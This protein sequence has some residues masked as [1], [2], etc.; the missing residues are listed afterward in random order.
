[1]YY[2][3]P[4]IPIGV[5]LYCGSTY[6]RI[7]PSIVALTLDLISEQLEGGRPGT[8]FPA[9]QDFFYRDHYSTR[10]SRQLKR[11][12][13]QIVP[14]RSWPAPA[15]HV[16]GI[17]RQLASESVAKSAWIFLLHTG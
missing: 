7:S 6:Y 1:V 17:L 9:L 13:D 12:L 4:D 16:I 15:V 2:C 14:D 5:D 11:E 8:R 10:A 3:H